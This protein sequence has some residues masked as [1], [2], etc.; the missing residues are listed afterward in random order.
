M[1][2]EEGEQ[3][4]REDL[5]GSCCD[6]GSGELFR[7]ARSWFGNVDRDRLPWSAFFLNSLRLVLVEALARRCRRTLLP[8]LH[9]LCPPFSRLECTVVP[10]SRLQLGPSAGFGR[11]SV[12]SS[13][14]RAWVQ[15]EAV[16]MACP[17]EGGRNCIELWL[18][19]ALM[20]DSG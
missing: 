8:V 18:S 5:G 17:A 11:I 19:T 6:C 20:G 16:A 13:V 15:C 3:D 4:H 14:V 7:T 1:G 10:V 2:F 9:I 12:A